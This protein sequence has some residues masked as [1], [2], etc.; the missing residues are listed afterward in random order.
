[1]H[2]VKWN[3]EG[4]RVGRIDDGNI[5]CLTDHL[6]SFTMVVLDVDA[7]VYCDIRENLYIHAY[8]HANIFIN[9]LEIHAC[10]N[11]SRCQQNNYIFQT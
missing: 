6:S 5:E 9:S 3:I 11:T 2:G 7:K 10:K 8:I 4:M 1:L